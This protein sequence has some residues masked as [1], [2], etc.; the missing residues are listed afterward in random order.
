ML[1]DHTSIIKTILLRFCRNKDG[2]IPDMG[3]RVEGANHLGGLLAN[4]NARRPPAAAGYRHLTDT[5]ADRRRRLFQE[6][7][8]AQAGA[9][10]ARPAEL[11]DWQQEFLDAKRAFAARAGTAPAA[12]A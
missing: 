1:F 8:A 10:P 12:R 9:A 4:A 5:L 11:T 2:T 6:T 7:I 3:A